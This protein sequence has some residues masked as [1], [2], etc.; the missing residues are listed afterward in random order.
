MSADVSLESLAPGPG[1]EA[2]RP[3]LL[4]ADEPVPLAG[5]LQQGEL[6]VLSGADGAVLGATLVLMES[7]EPG[8]AELKNVA[9]AEGLH[10]RGLGRRM[11]AMV[12]AELRRRG[13]RRAVVGTSN[14][15]IGE[16]AFYQK[17]GF[18]LW[19]IERDYFTPEKGYDPEERQNGLPHRDMVWFDREL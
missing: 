15:S 11:L 18:R 7:D 14:A 2:L 6:F 12:L 5:Y 19:R 13:V 9:V 8:T 10:G 16:I 4:H 17:C 3:L 1:R